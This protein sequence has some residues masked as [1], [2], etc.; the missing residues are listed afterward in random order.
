M[1]ASRLVPPEFGEV[2]LEAPWE[3]G[4]HIGDFGG[5]RKKKRREVDF[6]AIFSSFFSF[7]HFSFFLSKLSVLPSDPQSSTSRTSDSS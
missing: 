7:F 4:F 5:G 3:A 1:H 6:S 2:E